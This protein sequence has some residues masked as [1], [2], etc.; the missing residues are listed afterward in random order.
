M[1]EK[2]I[3]E[4][5]SSKKSNF[6]PGIYQSGWHWFYE[7]TSQKEDE[8]TGLIKLMGY[9]ICCNCGGRGDQFTL[10]TEIGYQEIEGRDFCSLDCV[11]EF[12]VRGDWNYKPEALRNALQLPD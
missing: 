7:I 4:V 12:A 10:E 11:A 2:C 5:A 1:E 8:K 9:P 6:P 3:S